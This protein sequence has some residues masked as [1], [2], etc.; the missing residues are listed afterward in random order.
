MRMK[1]HKN[2]VNG[3]YEFYPIYELDYATIHDLTGYSTEQT[4]DDVSGTGYKYR[5]WHCYNNQVGNG[6]SRSIPLN[7]TSE[8]NIIPFSHQYN[9][10]RL[11]ARWYLPEDVMD[12]LEAV[13]V[14]QQPDDWD[15]NPNYVTLW[16]PEGDIESHRICTPSCVRLGTTFDNNEHYYLD[17]KRTQL[18]L[19]HTDTGNHFAVC[20]AAYYNYD[21]PSG[22]KLGVGAYPAYNF[23]SPSNYQ[24]YKKYLFGDSE[25]EVFNRNY[26]MNDDWGITDISS[27]ADYS[28]NMWNIGKNT[29]MVFVHF[30]QNSID[31]Y[32]VAVIQMNNFSETAEPI[33]IHVIA[34]DTAFWG[35]SITSGGE[36]GQ[37][38]WGT[39]NQPSYSTGSFSGRSD[40]VG[41]GADDPNSLTTRI[42]ETSDSIKDLFYNSQLTYPTFNTF[43]MTYTDNTRV[44]QMLGAMLTPSSWDEW[45]NKMYNPLSGVLSF[46][47][48]PDDFVDTHLEPGESAI[49]KELWISGINISAK[50]ADKYTLLNNP[51]FRVLKN[52]QKKSFDPVD[53]RTN[54]WFGSFPDFAPYTDMILHLPFVGDVKLNVNNCMYGSLCVEY[55]CDLTS[56]NVVAEVWMKDQDNKTQYIL[57]ADGN[58]MYNL[59][60][61]QTSQDGSGFGKV[62]IGSAIGLAGMFTVN[63]PMTAGGL[64]TAVNGGNQY[65][66]TQHEHA[67]SGNLG[68]NNSLMTH[69]DVWLEITRPKWVENMFYQKLNGIPSYMS[70]YISDCGQNTDVSGNPIPTGIAYDG[71]L[72]ISEIELDGVNATDAEKE[73]IEALLKAGV[74]IRGDELV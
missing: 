38:S 2:T 16:T 6:I 40:S 39:N 17:T 11:D 58:C 30:V 20:K 73:E 70:H 63:I 7:E 22:K 19:F 5:R 24:S 8:G 45:E 21:R 37:G 43:L 49:V 46:G 29:P 65:F 26:I 4:N 15:S 18:R 23:N 67:K 25:D 53:L 36:S 41:T 42:A 9:N 50:M 69:K 68:G 3:E 27:S 52:L 71:Y 32:G 33:A 62:L 14:G 66:N 61:F 72:K 12:S 56:G 55:S 35:S 64:L 54:P 10:M 47:L 74:Y 31:F 28:W 34:W 51:T 44:L 60:L 48:V 59:P 57:S 13:P 1:L